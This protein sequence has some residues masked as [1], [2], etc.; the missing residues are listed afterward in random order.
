M[1]DDNDED[2]KIHKADDPMCKC[3]DCMAKRAPN[4]EVEKRLS[5]IEK[6]NVDLL[7]ENAD[8]KKSV[9]TEIE[10]RESDEMTVVLKGFKHTSIDLVKDVPHFTKMRKN[11]P[12]GY[13]RIMEIMKATDASASALFS[14]IGTRRGVGEGSAYAQIEALADKVMEK[15][16]DGMTKEQ[17]IEKVLLDPKNKALV[18]SYRE[19]LQ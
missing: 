8:L 3:A 6:Q 9:A 16:V 19:E 5:A 2:D 18:K 17:A 15:G 4:P 10:K 7:K 1:P 13:A 11:D 12:E 14:D